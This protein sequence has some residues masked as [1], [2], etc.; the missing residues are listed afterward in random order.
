[1]A[2]GGGAVGDLAGFAAATFLRGVPLVILPTTLLAQV[3]ASIG[4][5][6]AVNLPEGKNLVG[7]F[8]QPALVLADTE[9][10]ATLPE[11]EFR[12]GLAE[13]VKLGAVADAA[14]FRR[15]EREAARI[16]AR[17][18]RVVAGLVALAI[19]WK[20]R[21]VADD[22]RD[23][24]G[25]RALLNYGHTLGHA[26]EAACGFRRLL[27]G[28]AVAI[29]IAGAARLAAATGLMAPAGAARQEALLARLGLP[30]RVP[31]GV[32]RRALL[33]AIRADKKA[34]A[35]RPAFVLTAKIGSGRLRWLKS[36]RELNRVLVELGCGREGGPR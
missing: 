5:K 18:P 34:L 1:M 16:L 32:T 26:I 24:R 4:G 28:E 6:N 19:R 33:R 9:T 8:H 10:L 7:A 29:G 36:T 17:E 22:E 27:H 35:G 30:T 21:L 31:P 23:L 12:A 3:D 11:R 2:L 20:A 15:I 13:V 14:L 25:R